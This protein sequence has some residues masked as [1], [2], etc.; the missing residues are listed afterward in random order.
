MRKVVI[1]GGGLGGLSLAIRLQSKGYRVT[2]LEKN[3]KIGGQASQLKQK[4]YTFDLGPSLFTA[5][6]IVRKLFS[7]AGAR[8]EDY[9]DLVPLD[10][11]YRIYFNDGSYLDYSG[12][13]DRMRQ[14][15]A[16]FD[17]RDARN[18]ARF[19]DCSGALYRFIVEQGYG[20]RPFDRWMTML[21]FVPQALLLKAFLPAYH[22]AALYFRNFRHRFA[23]SFHPLFLGGSPFRT[24]AVY[25]MIPYLEKTE[26]VWYSA[27]GMYSLVEVL[28]ALFQNRG[29]EIRT[30][31][32]VLQILVEGHRACGVATSRETFRAD[33]VVSSAD[34]QHTY[35]QL[36]G[37]SHRR[38]WND[39]RLRRMRYGMSVFL[40]YLGVKKRYSQLL[41]HTLIL[42]KRYRS[43]V[44]DIFDRHVIPEDF[45]MYL[46][47]PSRTEAA[48]AP[49]GCESMYVLVPVTNLQGDVNWESK[50]HP[51][52][53]QILDYLEH[54]FGLDGLQEAIEVKE[55]FTPLDFARRRNCHEGAPWGLEPLFTQIAIFRPQNRSEDFDGLYLVGASTH[56]GAGVPGVMLTAEATELAILQD[57][58]PSV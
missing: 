2:V 23:F 47:V 56:P 48:M 15:M 38:K 19:I 42:S 4:G 52:S 9:L 10:P 30:N 17:G 26:G 54:D 14:Q 31:H 44:K 53:Q 50:A 49:P 24:P 55:M 33:A 37:S 32:E 39:R 13:G 11:F 20:S 29:G 22:L 16:N 3:A 18:Y 45:S 35:G 1:I 58:P 28:A 7:D 27:G 36:L 12:D 51:F 34:L 21:N 6:G 41:H 43:L 5:P 8:M 46:H 40:I 25:Q 57:L